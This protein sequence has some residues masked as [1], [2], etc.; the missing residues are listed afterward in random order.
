MTKE[1]EVE[2]GGDPNS[3]MSTR[4]V[5]AVFQFVNSA[6]VRALGLTVKGHVKVNLG[7]AVPDFHAGQRAGAIHATLEVQVFGQ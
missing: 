1:R 7:V 3:L 2:R 6:A 5:F 4:E